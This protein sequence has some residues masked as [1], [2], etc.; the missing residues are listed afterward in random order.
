MKKKDSHVKVQSD[1]K[2]QHQDDEEQEKNDEEMDDAESEGGDEEEDEE[3]QDDR[4]EEGELENRQNDDDGE[5]DYEDDH[6]EA[7]RQNDDYE[8]DDDELQGRVKRRQNDDYQ[9]EDD[10]EEVSENEKQDKKRKRWRQRADVGSE[11]RQLDEAHIRHLKKMAE[12]ALKN[13]VDKKN[14]TENQEQSMAM[15]EA[16]KQHDEQLKRMADHLPQNLRRRRSIENLSVAVGAREDEVD[17]E[18][19][20]GT[21]KL[22]KNVVEFAPKD[23]HIKVLSGAIKVLDLHEEADM[24]VK[25]GSTNRANQEASNEK[26]TE[27]NGHQ[28]ETQRNK[29][30]NGKENVAIK[31]A[32]LPQSRSLTRDVNVEK[33]LN[34]SDQSK[35]AVKTTTN[36]T[37]LREET[38]D[39]LNKSFVKKMTE[40]H[41]YEKEEPS[42]LHLDSELTSEE[43]NEFRDKIRAWIKE[44]GRLEEKFKEE[45]VRRKEFLEE[46][47]RK[48]EVFKNETST[49]L[50]KDQFD[51][52]PRLV[53]GIS[54]EY[55]GE[56]FPVADAR[57]LRKADEQAEQMMEEEL[58]L[59]LRMHN[60]LEE[61]VR[62]EE[63]LWNDV[64]EME[65]W[66]KKHHKKDRHEDQRRN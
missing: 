4:R 28:N 13:H 51:N 15:E 44:K 21:E 32:Q 37:S 66:R 7:G 19:E 35:L 31:I 39:S 30:D 14:N 40:E 34:V 36:G 8:E 1:N 47:A 33:K 45:E 60:S 62:E 20:A 5:Y 64:K 11:L 63:R 18:S 42:R 12:L 38:L 50:N 27:K 65:G 6:R 61:V 22:H 9:Y 43:S 55:F 17:K 26:T 3:E 16:K 24:T 57:K 46:L 48:E 23:T 53:A 10:Y 29:G 52:E 25:D 41:V 2:K 56:N 54:A 49:T 59:A 58:D